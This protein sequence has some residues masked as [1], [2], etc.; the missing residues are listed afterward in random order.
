M[1][2]WESSYQKLRDI[3]GLDQEKMLEDYS[4][5]VKEGSVLDIGIGEGRNVLSFAL[6]GHPI[7][8]ID[9]SKTA[10][11]RCASILEDSKC[12]YNLF[13]KTVQEFEIT[14]NTYSLI[15]ST[16]T[17]N[18][19][20]KT[21]AQSIVKSCLKGLNRQGL[22]YLGLFS[23]EDPQMQDYLTDYKC[24]DKDSYYI[25]ERDIVKSYFEMSDVL[26]LV[27]ERFEIICRKQDLSLDLGHGE[28]HYHGA[29]EILIRRNA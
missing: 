18:F 29:I 20:K 14:E 26:S 3:W 17:L 1:N 16:W 27:D 9:V 4:S 28:E 19:M 15:I 6:K 5:L 12:K 13:E 22:L 8:G 23:T 7:I 11:S 2:N 10:L 25:P 21:E 24:V